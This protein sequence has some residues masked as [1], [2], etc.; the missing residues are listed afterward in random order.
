MEKADCL[1]S[2]FTSAPLKE[3]MLFVFLFSRTA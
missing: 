1:W 3:L 2:P